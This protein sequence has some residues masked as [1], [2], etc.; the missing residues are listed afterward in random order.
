[1]RHSEHS[2]RRLRLLRIAFAVAVVCVV[3]LLLF[4]REAIELIRPAPSSDRMAAELLRADERAD[5]CTAANAV[6]VGLRGEYFSEASLRGPASLV[7][8]DSVVD[9][10]PSMDWPTGI[11]A[12]PASVR[13]S[14]WIKPPLS[15]RYRF[16]A[17]A[18]NMKVLVARNLVAGVGAAPDGIVDMAA[19]RFYPIEIIVSQ[20]TN[21]DARIRLEWTAP[22]GARYVVPKALLHLPSE[23][24]ATP[25]S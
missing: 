23:T 12:R 1:M 11:A 15:G 22:H 21:S 13:W 8:V 5:I 9:F 7:R 16:H 17:D 14:G 4:R 10:S 18:P 24:I 25:H 20:I 19:G 3:A 2:S 6:G